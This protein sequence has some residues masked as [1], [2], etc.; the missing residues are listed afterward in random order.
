MLAA[1]LALFLQTHYGAT[2]EVRV[3]NIDVVVTDKAGHRV[4]GLTKDDFEVLE[5]GK[6]QTITNFYEAAL[7]TTPEAAT[8][9]RPR[10]FIIFVDNDSLAPNARRQFF[11]ALRGFADVQLHTGDQASLIS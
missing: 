10:R 1:L 11:A 7:A 5:D 2:V 6:R 4:T 8:P 9:A 3:V